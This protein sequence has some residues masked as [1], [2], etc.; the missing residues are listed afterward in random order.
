MNK[1]R[2]CIVLLAFI[3]LFAQASVHDWIQEKSKRSPAEATAY[4]KTAFKYARLNSL[5]PLLILAVIHVESRFNTKA[6]S[7]KGAIGPMQ[8]IP[9]WHPDEVR[10]VKLDSIDGGVRAGSAILRKYISSSKSTR[11]ALIKY[12]GGSCAYAQTVL[13]TYY[14]LKTTV[15]SR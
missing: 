2:R 11:E 5:D 14:G 4:L 10:E 15:A 1:F 12:S 9:R 6:K 8:V 7:N 3:P 13:D